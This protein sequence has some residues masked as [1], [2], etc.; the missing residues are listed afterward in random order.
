MPNC[1]SILQRY[2]GLAPQRRWP[3]TGHG[4]GWASPLSQLRSPPLYSLC[5]HVGVVV[6]L[7]CHECEVKLIDEKQS[8]DG[9]SQSGMQLH[10]PPKMIFPD[11]TRSLLELCH[12]LLYSPHPSAG[13][14]KQTTPSL[15]LYESKFV[16][17]SEAD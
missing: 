16:L 5:V 2:L 3:T 14:Q 9:R 1:D 6:L 11:D 8:V 4:L 13:S 15:Q 17:M 10:T 7:C 12:L